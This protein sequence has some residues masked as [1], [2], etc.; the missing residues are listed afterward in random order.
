MICERR[1]NVLRICDYEYGPRSM[2]P[3]CQNMTEATELRT[4]LAAS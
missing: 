3:R 4:G 2:R 1:N